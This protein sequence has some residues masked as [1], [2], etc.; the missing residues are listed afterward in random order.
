MDL[1]L[2]TNLQNSA[3]GFIKKLI[4]AKIITIVTI[5]VIHNW[6]LACVL[7]EFE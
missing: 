7:I 6:N 4:K 5:V 3:L 1:A 2:E